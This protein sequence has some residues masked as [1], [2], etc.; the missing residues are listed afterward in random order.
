LTTY[1][2]RTR[3]YNEDQVITN[4]SSVLSVKTISAASPYTT[5]VGSNEGWSWRSVQPGEKMQSGT[6]L[7]WQ[8]RIWK[9]EP[10]MKVPSGEAHDWIWGDE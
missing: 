3:A 1:W 2:Y 5:K 10:G 8:W 6:P 4:P 9:S 7:D